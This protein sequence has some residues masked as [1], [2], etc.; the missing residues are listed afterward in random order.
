MLATILHLSM[1]LV[2]G[3]NEM[4]RKDGNRWRNF[5]APTEVRLTGV[6]NI[7]CSNRFKF[8]SDE[9]LATP[10]RITA[11]RKAGSVAFIDESQKP[12]WPAASM[13]APAGGR[14]PMVAG[15]L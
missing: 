10:R 5:A 8:G 13:L 3:L 7:T 4:Q 1:R 6:S 15:S 12:D 2:W 14:A 11:A 9:T